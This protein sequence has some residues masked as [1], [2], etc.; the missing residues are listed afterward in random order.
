MEDPVRPHNGPP[1]HA[2]SGGQSAL[3]RQD[4][5]CGQERSV[6]E[7]GQPVGERAIVGERL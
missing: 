1:G 3:A 5:G 4:V 2:Q 6:D 7:A